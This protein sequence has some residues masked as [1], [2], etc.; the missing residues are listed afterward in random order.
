MSFLSVFSLWSRQP[1]RDG[2][3]AFHVFPH[4]LMSKNP[5]A[6]SA[7]VPTHYHVSV[8]C[9]FYVLDQA[10]LGAAQFLVG[11]ARCAVRDYR[12]YPLQ[13]AYSNSQHG[14]NAG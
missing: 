9:Q 2:G 10:A 14:V 12:R 4:C 11:T 1:V 6:T 5:P 3:A 13:V 7:V 8:S